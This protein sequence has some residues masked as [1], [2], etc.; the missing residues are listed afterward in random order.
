MAEE[1]SETSILHQ[2]PPAMPLVLAMSG[3]LLIACAVHMLLKARC[4]SYIWKDPAT[5]KCYRISTI[6]G[7]AQL[8]GPVRCPPGC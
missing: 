5:R 7:S 2:P 1:T 6:G 3:I 8:T 4:P